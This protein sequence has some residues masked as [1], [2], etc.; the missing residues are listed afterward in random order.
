MIGKLSR[1]S[2]NFASR[3]STREPSPRDEDVDDV[4]KISQQIA[5]ALRKAEPYREPNHS[6]IS[7]PAK[8]SDKSTSN[9][10]GEKSVSFSRETT[11]SEVSQSIMSD[12]SIES[13][14][15]E[16]PQVSHNLISVP[17]PIT[18]GMAIT[19]NH[20]LECSTIAQTSV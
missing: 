18:R 3:A 16:L 8:A 13:G 5:Q 6:K 9:I 10:S 7:L 12:V 19:S 15:P 20:R 4:Q 1:I 11:S 2:P 17:A 14:M